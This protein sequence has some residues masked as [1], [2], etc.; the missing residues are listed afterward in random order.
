MA[1]VLEGWA[2]AADSP[3]KAVGRRFGEM[4]E[5]ATAEGKVL[6]FVLREVLERLSSL[7]LTQRGI[8]EELG[9]G[10]SSSQL[11]R[12]ACAAKIPTPEQLGKLLLLVE[13]KVGQRLPPS[14]REQ[15]EAANLRAMQAMKSDVLGMLTA[16]QEARQYRR[17]A[18]EA[19]AR[20]AVVERNLERVRRTLESLRMELRRSRAR[21]L[22][23]SR[24]AQE[25]ELAALREVIADLER[26]IAGLTDEAEQLRGQIRL[27]QAE[28]ADARQALDA[29]RARAVEAE[30]AAAQDRDR[31]E[32]LGEEVSV[33]TDLLHQARAELAEL[34][35][36]HEQDLARADVLAEAEAVVE[37]AK[38]AA[39]QPEAVRQGAGGL[40][41]DFEGESTPSQGPTAADQ[42]R[43]AG[44]SATPAEVAARMLALLETRDRDA[45]DALLGAVAERRVDD[46]VAAL[47]ALGEAGCYRERE[48]LTRACAS[49]PPDAVVALLL[50][51][52]HADAASE[53]GW[54][55]DETARTATS[56]VKDLVTLLLEHRERAYARRLLDSAV[57]RGSIADVIALIEILEQAWPGEAEWLV[58]ETVAQRR[59]S[60][61]V[62]V[63]SRLSALVAETAVQ[64]LS[65]RPASTVA[66]A[67]SLFAVRGEQRWGARLA[68]HAAGRPPQDVT[69]LVIL[70]G[71]DVSEVERDW[72]LDAYLH[73]RADEA[74]VLLEHLTEP[75][76][77]NTAAA[78]TLM[79]KVGERGN[80]AQV[81]EVAEYA[82]K[83][84]LAVQDVLDGTVHR[85]PED[86]WGLLAV[87]AHRDTDVAQQLLRL[88]MTGLAVPAAA[89]VLERCLESG[90]GSLDVLAT[91]AG[92][93]SRLDTVLQ[94]ADVLKQRGWP[95]DVSHLL[96]KAGTSAA[97]TPEALAD[98]LQSGVAT[99]ALAPLLTGVTDLSPQ[100]LHRVICVLT[101]RGW[102]GYARLTLEYGPE[103]QRIPDLARY[104]SESGMPD[105]AT[106]LYGRLVRTASPD[107]LVAVVAEASATTAHEIL[108][109]AA[110]KPTA[111]LAELVSG[112]AR[113]G[114]GHYIL[115]LLHGVGLGPGAHSRELAGLLAEADRNRQSAWLFGQSN[116]MRRPGTELPPAETFS[117]AVDAAR[118]L[119]SADDPDAA[120][121]ILDRAIAADEVGPVEI[122]DSL[123]ED[124]LR[125]YLDHHLVQ[126]GDFARHLYP[127]SP[128]A[129]A[130]YL[131][132]FP[133]GTALRP[134]VIRLAALH[135]PVQQCHALFA[136][137]HV[138]ADSE[139]MTQAYR[140]A[141]QRPSSDVA[142][143]VRVLMSPDA[144]RARLLLR[145]ALVHH[146]VE[147]LS[148]LL[149][150]AVAHDA[151]ATREELEALVA[152][153]STAPA[154][155]EAIHE[156]FAPRFAPV[157]NIAG[158][159]RPVGYYLQDPS[160]TTVCYWDGDS[161]TGD[162]LPL[163]DTPGA[164]ATLQVQALE[165]EQADRPSDRARLSRRLAAGYSYI[166]GPEHKHTLSARHAYIYWLGQGSR[167]D[168]ARKACEQ[169]IADC[170]RILGPDDEFTL[171]ARHNHAEWT[172]EA[173]HA[174]EASRLYARLAMD[175]VRI[176]GQDHRDTLVIAAR[177]AVWASRAGIPQAS[178]LL[179]TSITKLNAVLDAEPGATWALMRRGGVLLEACLYSEAIADFTGV[180]RA[181]PK[182]AW[183][184]AHRAEAHRE[185]S[186]HTEAVGD[187]T[188]A[189]R[190]N[191]E[192][193]W[194]MARRGEVHREAGRYAPAITDFTDALSLA[195]DDAWALARRGEAHREIGHYDEAIADFTKALALQPDDAWALGSRGET[196]RQVGNFDQAITD[197]TAAIDREP[198]LAWAFECRGQA[199]RQ[200]GSMDQAIEDYSAA[201]RLDPD[202]PWSLIQRGV[203]HREMQNFAQ[204]R[205]DLERAQACSPTPDSPGLTFELLLLDTLT[206]DFTSCEQRWATLL[207]ASVATR[208]SD[209]TRFFTLFKS[210][211]LEPKDHVP[212]ATRTFL[213]QEPDQDTLTDLVHYLAELSTMSEQI[214]EQA[215]QCARLIVEHDSGRQTP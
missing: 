149:P 10:F 43:E 170:D 95:H 64:E 54:L 60:D 199:H 122:A 82:Q 112:L 66:G 42:A 180:L 8:G 175:R 200:V 77:G 75:Q 163:T 105:Y 48:Q 178:F 174:E 173:H 46:V 111:Y 1:G 97:Q 162:R 212:E 198:S 204:A 59:T 201:I 2:D 99:W 65:T 23:L 6:A 61:V 176:N 45:A 160:D 7:G 32:R 121:G 128:Q 70:L 171:L 155:A 120:V 130:A 100:D 132:R 108:L 25:P 34:Q 4:A 14:A 92:S 140:A 117:E 13:V 27:Y 116:L 134:Q 44:L 179:N 47:D 193:A 76:H 203:A 73:R 187:F 84:G 16:Q 101:A 161:W 31:R 211:L 20:G 87:L 167:V 96:R 21:E 195:P 172:G 196:H 210:L 118:R 9:A 68:E 197:L 110:T 186:S 154:A 12:M 5:A 152:E 145:E 39:Q 83:Q 125:F 11:S 33:L 52:H 189:L 184:L 153:R 58:R 80:P 74:L 89:D 107:V 35:R 49:R 69:E 135:T 188:A 91:V 103:P 141:A 78:R 123:E 183:C 22:Q 143:M 40:E 215:R 213:T 56:N 206:T 190:V 19:Q 106:A 181:E 71:E 202:D 36:E 119:F 165:I 67:L 164:R 51:L 144:G 79:R 124:L 209:A 98:V 30:H 136:A 53:A 88:V 147:D 93:V 194:A 168:Q 62:T 151:V 81:E 72:L 133:P 139:E 205:G 37:R 182:N 208:T 109:L 191:P 185:Y 114:C 214:A 113:C 86:V 18:E 41:G 127:D 24:P 156:A 115:I 129:L 150:L 50:A 177:Q 29:Q 148:V 158:S 55:L 26:S 166:L 94:L 85:H 137:L 142:A 3:G 159:S 157:S 17:Q 192:Y 63:V 38:R 102:D 169:L 126:G 15:F 131:K 90:L 104:L 57:P 146:A 138:R 28:L 207:N